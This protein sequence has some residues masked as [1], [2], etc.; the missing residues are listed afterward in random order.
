MTS[1]IND[2]KKTRGRPPVDSDRVNVRIGRSELDA[3]DAFSASQ[4][5][6]P[7]RVEAIR[8]ILR[9]WLHS[10]GYLDTPTN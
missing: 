1:T 4:E 5:D 10:H 6:N 7:P 3:I 9:D 8:R 2:T